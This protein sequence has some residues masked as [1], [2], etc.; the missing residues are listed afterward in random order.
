M[1]VIASFSCVKKFFRIAIRRSGRK[2][3]ITFPHTARGEIPK[4]EY[5]MLF[6]ARRMFSQRGAPVIEPLSPI[7]AGKPPIPFGKERAKPTLKRL[8]GIMT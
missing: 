6:R 7:L 1:L 4:I 2:I 5:Q 3:D 8:T